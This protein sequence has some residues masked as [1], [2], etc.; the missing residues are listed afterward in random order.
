MSRS[1]ASL[2][3][4]KTIVLLGELYSEQAAPFS[5]DHVMLTLLNKVEGSPGRVSRS[6][7]SEPDHLRTLNPIGRLE[8]GSNSVLHLQ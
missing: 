3:T 1:S 2:N 8:M 6:L 5:A 4:L 7:G